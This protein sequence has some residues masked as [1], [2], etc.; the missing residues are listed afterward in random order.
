MELAHYQLQFEIV[1][2]WG[3]TCLAKK[4]ARQLTPSEGYVLS[5]YSQPD[6]LTTA[7]AILMVYP[8]TVAAISI[9]HLVRFAVLAF[10]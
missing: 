10:G 4:N 5:H 8:S 2:Y 9:S 1:L 6:E 7:T 3:S